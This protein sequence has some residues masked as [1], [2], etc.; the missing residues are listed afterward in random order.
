MV[1]SVIVQQDL[2]MNESLFSIGELQLKHSLE[3][4][5]IKVFIDIRNKMFHLLI[6]YYSRQ[7]LKFYFIVCK[8]LL[9]DCQIFKLWTS[10]VGIA[11][12]EME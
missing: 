1:Y 12:N 4:F 10:L 6:I 5:I 8:D 3:A 7:T 9:V 2:I 11:K